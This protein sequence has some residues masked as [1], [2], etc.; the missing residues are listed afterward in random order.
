[1]SSVADFKSL[2]LLSYGT[3]AIHLALAANYFYA[4]SRQNIVKANLS[5]FFSN[6]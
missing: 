5:C 3:R 2:K 4:I 6:N 1:M